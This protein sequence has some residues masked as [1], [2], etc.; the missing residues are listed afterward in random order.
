M[1][2][3]INASA[4]LTGVMAVFVVTL[5]LS[6]HS[7]GR[8][9]S[10]PAEDSQKSDMVWAGAG[11]DCSACH[12]SYADS[13]KDDKLLIGKHEA[14][15]RECSACHKEQD[16]ETAHEGVTEAPGKFF[17]QRRY[18]DD[19]CVMCHGGYDKLV[20]RTKDSKAFVTTQ[21][22]VINPHDTHQGKAECFNCHKMHQ[23][24]APIEYCYGCHHPRQLSNCRDCHAPG[25]E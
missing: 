16:M 3:N 2:R 15:T 20:E 22:E 18:P 8:A 12:Q 25:N 23:D 19:Q 9:A 10:K 24:R 21:N 13:M 7:M 1:F 11:S 6:V 5:L 14:M 4:L 17:R